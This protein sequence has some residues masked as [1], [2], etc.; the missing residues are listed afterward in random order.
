MALCTAAEVKLLAREFESV[1][2]PVIE[3]YIGLAELEMSEEAW[4]SRA[5][6]ACMW[7]TCH[8]MIKGGVLS[9]STSGS[10]AGS[11]QSVSVGDVSVSY[12]G[13]EAAMFS[14]GLDAS[15]GTTRYGVEYA[16]LI[17]LAVM[18]AA[19]AVED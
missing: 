7:L 6:L 14:Q 16:R 10:A 15:L 13:L 8:L 2:I 5:G 3:F 11:V 18:G 17:S 12:G 19:L 1:S 9:T 4:G